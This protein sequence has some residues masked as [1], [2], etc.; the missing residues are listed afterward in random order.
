[1]VKLAAV[2]ASDQQQFSYIGTERES[3]KMPIEAS[4]RASAQAYPDIWL[5]TN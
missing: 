3:V 5:T 2:Q 1:M 4:T